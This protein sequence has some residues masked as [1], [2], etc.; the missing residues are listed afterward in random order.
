MRSGTE[1][2]LNE[3]GPACRSRLAKNFE[4]ELTEF[5]ILV[6]K[7]KEPLIAFRQELMV[8]SAEVAREHAYGLMHKGINALVAGFELALSGFGSE[9][10]ILYRNSVEICAVGWDIVSNE[11]SL[12]KFLKNS[13]FES[14]SS[15]KSVAKVDVLYGF[16]WGMLSNHFVHVNKD[17]RTPPIRDSSIGRIYQPLGFIPA[18]EEEANRVNIEA[19]LLVAHR[20]LQL[21]EITFFPYVKNPEAVRESVPGKSVEKH[22][23]DRHAVFAKSFEETCAKINKKKVAEGDAPPK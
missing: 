22:V 17:N 9:P 3:Y 20:C 7:M 6:D 2:Y 1:Q 23:S 5:S 8:D 21:I 10:N 11:K 13:N 15:I 12:I 14:S 18:G 16:L 19:G 4:I